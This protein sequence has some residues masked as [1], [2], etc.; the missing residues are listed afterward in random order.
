MAVKREAWSSGPKVED[1]D[2]DNSSEDQKK[3]IDLSADPTPH[4]KL[5]S[6]NSRTTQREPF[7]SPMLPT[8]DIAK[9]PAKEEKDEAEDNKS[10][11]DGTKLP[12]A[13]PALL[14]EDRVNELKS[15]LAKL[16]AEQDVAVGQLE[17]REEHEE[18]LLDRQQELQD[19]IQEQEALLTTA[20]AAKAEAERKRKAAI[21]EERKLRSEKCQVEEEL[22]KFEKRGTFEEEAEHVDELKEKVFEAEKDLKEAEVELEILQKFP[23]AGPELRPYLEMLRKVHRARPEST[24]DE[25]ENTVEGEARASSSTADNESVVPD[26]S[27]SEEV[28]DE[29][30]CCASL[31]SESEDNEFAVSDAKRKHTGRKAVKRRM[32]W[33]P[34]DEEDTESVQKSRKAQK[35]PASTGDVARGSPAPIKKQK[36]STSESPS[37]II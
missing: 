36:R 7:P 22:A 21:A 35:L 10:D 12:G 18:D 37:D 9:Q 1:S 19:E 23:D 33:T 3:H 13:A 26:A 6:K 25:A 14:E 11:I 2:S 20:R 27:D 8:C 16:R 32:S 34:S 4:P 29:A 5:A 30:K 15:I 17:H 28:I 31:Q 24:D